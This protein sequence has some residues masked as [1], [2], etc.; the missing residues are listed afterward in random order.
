MASLGTWGVGKRRT[1]E[2][3]AEYSGVDTIHGTVQNGHCRVQYVPWAADMQKTAYSEYG[4]A[5]AGSGVS[6]DAFGRRQGVRASLR[7]AGR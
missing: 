5:A 1:L 2:Q 4:G 3:Y 7:G 6:G